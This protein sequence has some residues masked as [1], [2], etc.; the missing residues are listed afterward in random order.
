MGL[1][2]ST[3]EAE[4]R[5]VEVRSLFDRLFGL[6]QDQ[7]TCERELKQ[8]RDSRGLIVKR[9]SAA[10]HL[11]DHLATWTERRRGTMYIRHGTVHYEGVVRSRIVRQETLKRVALHCKV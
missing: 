10:A 11:A 3:L 7:E 4:R 5:V 9:I 2:Y 1:K 8:S 6:F